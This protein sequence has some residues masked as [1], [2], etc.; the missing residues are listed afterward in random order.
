M[1]KLWDILLLKCS[2]GRFQLYDF[3]VAETSLGVSKADEQPCCGVDMALNQDLDL[4]LESVWSLCC[5]SFQI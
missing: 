5:L 3:A 1:Q 4:N 2:F